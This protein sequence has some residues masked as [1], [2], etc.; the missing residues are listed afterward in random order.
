M[1]LASPKGEGW[2]Q[3]RGPM[4]ASRGRV[5]NTRLELG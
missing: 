4:Q 1:G 3:F 2:T 5:P